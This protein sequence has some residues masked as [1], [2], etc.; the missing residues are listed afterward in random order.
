[1]WGVG[2]AGKE[3]LMA[4][5]RQKTNLYQPAVQR[6]LA[7]LNEDERKVVEG[8]IFELCEIN[9]I[10]AYTALTIIRKVGRC[11]LAA[12]REGRRD[13]RA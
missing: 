7:R 13:A 2:A 9:G 4:S 12:K 1:M 10:G 6:A 5:P 11:L 8:V 3:E